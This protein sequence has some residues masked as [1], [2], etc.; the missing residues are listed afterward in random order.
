MKNWKVRVWCSLFHFFH[1]FLQD[2]KFWYVNRKAFG[3]S[4]LYWVDFTL[5]NKESSPW[6]KVQTL[7]IWW[8]EFNLTLLLVGLIFAQKKI[9]PTHSNRHFFKKEM[10]KKIITKNKPFSCSFS[11]D[12][13]IEPRM[14]QDRSWRSLL[15]YPFRFKTHLQKSHSNGSNK[16]HGQF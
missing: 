5:F 14:P 1:V 4:L 6:K 2:F 7:F 13:W 8:V 9:Y 10:K 3:A 12:V 15:I 11:L 16:S